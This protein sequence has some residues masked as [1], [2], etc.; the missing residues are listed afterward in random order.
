MDISQRRLILRQFRSGNSRMLVTTGLLRGEDFSD[1]M[2][3]INYDFPKSPKDYVRKIVSCFSRKVKVI[4]FITKND[5]TAKDSIETAFNMHMLYL[6][7][8]LVDLFVSN[9]DS[10]NDQIFS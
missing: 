1:I 9:L 6:P 10:N 2:L 4:N 5:T 3:V 8:D 7:Q